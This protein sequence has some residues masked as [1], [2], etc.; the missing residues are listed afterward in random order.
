MG[1]VKNVPEY[2]TPG[3]VLHVAA[4]GRTFAVTVVKPPFH[5]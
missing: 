1:Y 4:R 3:S 5:K 2:T